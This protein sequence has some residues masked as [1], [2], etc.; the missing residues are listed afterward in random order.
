MRSFEH[1]IQYR[2]GLSLEGIIH[3]GNFTNLCQCDSCRIEALSLFP[4]LQSFS[5]HIWLEH[6]F[7]LNEGFPAVC[8]S[9]GNLVELCHFVGR[10]VSIT[11]SSQNQRQGIGLIPLRQKRRNYLASLENIPRKL[12]L[13]VPG[14]YVRCTSLVSVLMLWTH[15]ENNKMVNYSY[16]AT[17]HRKG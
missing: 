15:D 11:L 13:I 9:L 10:L 5:I 8:M 4:P 1:R 14:F 2:L 6:V 3:Q 7:Q 12:T 16:T 17:S